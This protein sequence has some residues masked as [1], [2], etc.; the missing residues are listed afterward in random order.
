MGGPLR[1][2]IIF[3][4][5]PVDADPKNPSTKLG[6]LLRDSPNI[7]DALPLERNETEKSFVNLNGESYE[8]ER[9][10]A[11]LVKGFA[12]YL[13]GKGH[14][15]CRHRMLPP[16]ES[17]PLFTDLY[18]TQLGL[19]VEA[20][21]SVTRESVRMAI[22]QLADYGR[23]VDHAARAILLP[24]KPRKDL[25]DLAQSQGCVVIWPG[26]K[27]YGSTEANLIT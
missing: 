20:K 21:G 18:S 12:D 3:R 10:E 23:F 9:P 24:S 14:E 11:G 27:A 6:R 17:R 7:V 4:L 26:G 5:K 13:T 16:G 2:V 22:G 8:A 19:L 15:S 1:R 25:L